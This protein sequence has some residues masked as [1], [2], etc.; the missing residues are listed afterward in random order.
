MNILEESGNIPLSKS[1][2]ISISPEAP[3]GGGMGGS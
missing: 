2:P 3:L 1:P